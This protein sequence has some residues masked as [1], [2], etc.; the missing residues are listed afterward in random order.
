MKKEGQI[1]IKKVIKKGGHG[2]HH[3]GAWKVAYADFVTAMMA[4]FMVLWLVAVMSIDSKKAVAEYFRS[5][6]VLQGLNPTSA[7]AG[8]GITI[9]QGNM[10]KLDEHP[11]GLGKGSDKESD[12]P[13]GGEMSSADLQTQLTKMVE[14]K[15]AEIKDQVLI[16][17]T[18]EGVRIEL[19]EKEGSPMFES[20]KAGVLEKGHKALDVIAGTLGK[21]P[22][23]LSIEGHTDSYKYQREDY[24][25]W[26]LAADRANAAR[27]ELVKHGVPDGKIKR[28][29]SF[30]DVVPL[31]P[32]NTFDPVNRRVSILVN[33]K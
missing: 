1:I 18:S 25:N 30:A 12:Q 24:T 17:T 8:K 3:G 13:I 20:G 31:K 33:S 15:L 14:E 26:E 23:S 7:G 2:G 29:T 11:G 5:S 28:I 4:L 9:M 27:R 21:V 16:F 19:V 22:N 10:L 32:E 6:S